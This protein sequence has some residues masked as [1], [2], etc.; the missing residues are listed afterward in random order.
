MKKNAV[1]ILFVEDDRVDRMAFE[2]FVDQGELP[3]DYTLAQSV[4]EARD[5][6]HSRSFDIIIADY[7]LGDGT[8]F[9]LFDLLA[10]LPVIITT[11][12][13]DE[14]IAVEAMKLGACDYIIKD[15]EERYLKIL[16]TAIEF[17]QKRK[18]DEKE[19]QQYHQRLEAMVEERTAKLQD[20]IIL[21]S[22]TEV[23][24][25]ES[26]KK[27]NNAQR[28]AQIG[29]WDL[30]LQAHTLQ[31]SDEVYTI[32]DLDQQRYIPSRE[33]YMDKIHPVDRAFVVASYAQALDSKQAYEIEYRL[34]LADN[35][36]KFIN[37]R[38]ETI[39]AEDGKPDRSVGTVQDITARKRSDEQKAELEA[40]LRQKFKM[41][42]IGIMA[43]GIA[44]NFNNN[45]SII[46]GNIELAQLKEQDEKIKSML[47]DAKTATLR[48]RDL[49]SQILTYSRKGKHNRAPLQLPLIIDETIKLLSATIPSTVHITQTICTG[50]EKLI[51]NADPS[52]IQEALL[53]LCNNAVFAMNELGELNVSLDSIDV[54][55]SAMPERSTCQPGRYAKLSVQDN[56]CG[57]DKSIIDKIF[58]PFFTTKELYAG[59]GMGLAS[60]QGI[61]E[62]HGGMIKVHTAPLQGATFELYFPALA[63][64]QADEKSF[65]PM[66][67]LR[68][69]EKVLFVDDNELLATLGEQM[70]SALGYQ[71]TAMSNSHE[72][73]K[74]FS[75]NQDYFDVVITD[76]TMPEL[77][78][79]ELVAEMRK[80][81]PDLPLIIC[82]GY[83]SKMDEKKAQKLGINAFCMK[84]LDLTEL[85][86]KLR[87]VLNW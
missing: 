29:S 42:A 84:P 64:A 34:Q 87:Q 11:G 25:R 44:H 16:P 39:Y 24:L 1:K 76:Q 53:N 57:I 7:S 4:A 28:I 71:V 75:A 67:L 70:L 58:D 60:V 21:H 36:I 74:L 43:G 73:L 31:W 48:A 30:D 54:P 77:S 3:Y 55:Q 9:D 72:A 27:L 38:A 61:V 50:C 85:S 10:D 47:S 35:S 17:A 65:E 14:E 80:L 22:K 19:L 41:E 82:T 78:G 69:T 51:I 45:L 86:H 32:F 18:W 8:C 2:R 49:I 56:G 15:S 12:M 79:Q 26:T 6:I 13:G 23:A 33:T 68:G 59:T 63:P 66:E 81:R 40:Q 52:Q 62:Q 83:S 46:L 37:E 5:L 20:E